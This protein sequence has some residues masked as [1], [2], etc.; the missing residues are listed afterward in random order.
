VVEV[1]NIT[2]FKQVLEVLVVALKTLHQL[3]E[4]AH[5]VKVIMAAILVAMNLAVVA[6]QVL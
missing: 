1:L 2:A 3:Q 6:A 5:L 4:A